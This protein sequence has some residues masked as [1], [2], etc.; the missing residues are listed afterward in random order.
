MQL[1]THSRQDSFKVC[2]KKHWFAY[3]LGL[4]RSLDAKALR[5]GSAYHTGLEQ[6]GLGHDL[7]TAVEAARLAYGTTPDGFDEYDWAIESE[8]VIRLL[9]GYQW[10]WQNDGLE[11]IA[12]E[13]SFELPL[14]NPATGKPSKIFAT[15]GKID[16]IVKLEDGRLAV[17]ESKLLGDDIGP[18][19]DLAM[20]ATRYFTT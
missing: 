5:M 17:K 11:Y 13:Q 3:E 20:S 4:R 1:L 19:S 7:A 10:R 12:S 18:D 16:G 2:R 6:L 14:L 8:T 15:A 9:C